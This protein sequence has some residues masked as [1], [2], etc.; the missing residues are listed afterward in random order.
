MKELIQTKRVDEDTVNINFLTF[1]AT[2]HLNYKDVD[3]NGDTEEEWQVEI[4][5]SDFGD[6]YD[7]GTCRDFNCRPDS[8]TS[9]AYL[10]YSKD[11]DY[12]TYLDDELKDVAVALLKEHPPITHHYFWAIQYIGENDEPQDDEWIDQEDYPCIEDILDLIYDK[13]KQFAGAF[14]SLHSQSQ[15]PFAEEHED[16]Y[17]QDDE[18]Y[19]FEITDKYAFTQNNGKVVIYSD[20]DEHADVFNW[21]SKRL[22]GYGWT[23]PHSVD[24]QVCS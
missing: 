3:E 11:D 4:P 13:V 24:F 6:Y 10:T 9:Y 14:I 16:V 1:T 18:H 12:E 15:S 7:G 23:R 19:W 5:C 17:P 20:D 2:A 21:E 22:E 8:S